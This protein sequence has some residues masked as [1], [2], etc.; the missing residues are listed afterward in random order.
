[1]RNHLRSTDAALGRW[2]QRLLYGITGLTWLSGAV[3][4]YLRYFRQV[5]GDLGL[6]ANPAQPLCLEIHGAAAM[7]FL[8]LFGSLLQHHVPSGW[9][10]ERQRLSGILLIASC[11]LLALT[12][13]GL[14]Y[15]GSL[16]VRHWT[17]LIH[18]AFGLLLPMAIALHVLL[19]RKRP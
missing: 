4:L 11:S 3:W 13:W 7:V 18:S 17:S 2:H 1:M 19:S 12:G 6:E 15:L 9:R 14:Y 8:I 16:S 10:Q 5:Q